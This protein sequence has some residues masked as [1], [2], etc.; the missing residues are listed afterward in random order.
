MKKSEL[1]EVVNALIG[2]GKILEALELISKYVS[3][4]DRYVENDVLLQTAAFNRNHR[5]YNNHLISR[6]NYETALAR[7]NY[8]ITQIIDMLPAQGNYIDLKQQGHRSPDRVKAKRKIL[9]LT[10]NPKDSVGLRLGEE[11]RRVKDELSTTTSRD[12]FELV[13]E[14]AVRVPTIT[15]ALQKHRPEIVHFS[16][17]GKGAKGIVVEDENGNSVLYPN[18]GLDRLFR[19]F[20]DNVNCVLLNAC[21][22]KEQAAIISKYDIHVIG[23]NEAIEDN[24]AISFAVG[25]YQSLG[26]GNDYEFAYE[27]AMANIVMYENADTPEIWYKGEII[28]S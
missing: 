20:K 22:S 9:F 19:L 27:I 16:G 15:R 18:K 8:A 28:A 10:A 12:S 17:H 4:V 25:F 14:P 24:A 5:D 7:I 26:E 3:G 1:I 11:F 23:M 21:Y 13:N 6:S 2:Q